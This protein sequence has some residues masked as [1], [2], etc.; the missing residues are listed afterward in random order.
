VRQDRILDL[1]RAIAKMTSMPAE[2]IGLRQ[3]GRIEQGFFADITVFDPAAVLDQ[4]TYED[5]FQPSEGI[6]HVLVN[7]VPV[8]EQGRPTGARPGRVLRRGTDTA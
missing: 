4:A 2:R 3:R 1:G 5:P 6:R 8:L 7:G